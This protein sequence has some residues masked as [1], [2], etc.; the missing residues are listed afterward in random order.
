MML[1]L[2]GNPF[3]AEGRWLRGNLHTHTLNSDGEMSPGQIVKAYEEAGYDFLSITDHGKLTGTDEL[4]PQGLLLIPGEEVCVGSSESGRFFH[5]VGVGIRG[6]IPVKDLDRSVSPQRAIDLIRGLGGEAIVAHPYWSGLT[7]NDLVGLRGHLGLEVYNTTCELAIGKGLSSVHWDGLL[8]KGLR[9][10][11]FAVD[12]A[13]SRERPYLPRDSCRACIS[14]RAE[15]T[16]EDCIMEGV[17][18]GLFYSSNGPEIRNIEIEEDEIRVSSSPARSIAFISNEWLGQKNTA[19]TG[20]I[21]EA[22][23]KL[24]GGETYVRVEVT[25]RE[26]RTA[27]SN[28]FFIEG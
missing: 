28:P 5:V 13:H 23:Y 4:S 1:S 8:A 20:T 2:F 18:R 3:E 14:V 22:C 11:G 15:S 17:R 7:Q 26:G 10:M 12:D 24:T 19:E 6:E 21:E 9:L 16:T 25:D 27:W